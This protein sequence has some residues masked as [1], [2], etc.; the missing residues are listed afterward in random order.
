MKTLKEATIFSTELGNLVAPY[1]NY[2]DA[3]DLNARGTFEEKKFLHDLNYLFENEKLNDKSLPLLVEW[4]KNSRA[5]YLRTS[6]EDKVERDHYS[7]IVDIPK[8]E[9][10]ITNYSEGEGLRIVKKFSNGVKEN[11]KSPSCV[12]MLWCLVSDASYVE[13]CT[14]FADFCSEFGYNEDSRKAEGI[15]KECCKTLKALNKMFSHEELET[16]KET[17]EDYRFKSKRA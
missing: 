10:F 12:G 5:V 1:L 16:L 3:E 8:S 11:M 14:E 7:L 15:F 13:N 2:A 4:L 9:A 17:F 6:K